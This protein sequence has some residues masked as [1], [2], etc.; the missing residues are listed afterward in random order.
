MS[1]CA[2]NVGLGA[3][4]DYWAD[5]GVT[6][7]SLEEH[8]YACDAC[9]ARVAWLADLGAMLP[10]ALER[11]GGRQLVLTTDAVAHLE[12]RGVR[13]RQYHF[14]PNGEI[15][16]TV[17]LDDDLLVSWIP[18]ELA[19]DEELDG[20]MVDPA[21]VELVRFESAPVDRAHKVFITAMPAEQI[22]LL[23]DI[24]VRLRLTARSPRGTRDV[25]ELVYNHTARR[26][27]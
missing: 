17:A 16:C 25:R 2:A 1:T 6:D 26:T 3:L 22:L 8:L 4:V 21:G 12:R 24:K 15:A 27:V 18:V 9:T 23:P 14:P 19:D 7:E 20:V 13:L 10:A 5:R 11:R